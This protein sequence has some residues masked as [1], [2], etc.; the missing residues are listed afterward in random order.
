MAPKILSYINFIPTNTVS[1]NQIYFVEFPS[2][3]RDWNKKMTTEGNTELSDV[4][5][6]LG[7]RYLSYWKRTKLCHSFGSSGNSTKYFIIPYFFH[8]K[9][10]H[11]TTSFDVCMLK[12][13]HF[14]NIHLRHDI[15]NLCKVLSFPYLQFSIR[16]N[17][18]WIKSKFLIIHLMYINNLTRNF[19]YNTKFC[20]YF[21]YD[22]LFDFDYINLI[23][24]EHHQWFG[25]LCT[26]MTISSNLNY[27][28]C[29]LCYWFVKDSNLFKEIIKLRKI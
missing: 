16:I 4:F 5:R 15:K 10:N 27:F 20:A 7:I 3:I 6:S 21:V 23:E 25:M 9:E 29:T 8:T 19:K 26:R 1:M 11:P 22:L 28:N 12:Y 18:V 17:Y 2:K 13:Y 24:Y 14:S